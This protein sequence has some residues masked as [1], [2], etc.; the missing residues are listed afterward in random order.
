MSPAWV[1]ICISAGG[2][3]L[4]IFTTVSVVSR[5]IGNWEK[6]QEYL[7]KDLD[8]DKRQT[9]KDVES[10]F[11]QN[12]ERKEEHGKLDDRFT[13]FRVTIAKELG[14]NGHS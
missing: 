10:L 13:E 3:L 12:R 1:A 14:I 9:E 5:K 11:A 2:F 4:T 8:K 7:R 6:E